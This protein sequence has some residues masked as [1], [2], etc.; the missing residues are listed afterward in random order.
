[1][2][3]SVAGPAGITGARRLN[4]SALTVDVANDWVASA[5]EVSELAIVIFLGG[6]AVGVEPI[7]GV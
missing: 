2:V 1:M 7:L 3:E 4:F 5:L 6:H